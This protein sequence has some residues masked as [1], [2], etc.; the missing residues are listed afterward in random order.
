MQALSSVMPL[1]IGRHEGMKTAQVPTI[2][3]LGQL[4]PGP[5]CDVVE[6]GHW[7]IQLIESRESNVEVCLVE[8]FATADQIA[9][10]RQDL[11]GPPLRFKTFWCGP[12]RRM[13]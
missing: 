4:I 5:K 7:P 1:A 10:D 12:L 2:E 3:R 9:V 8:D 11:E 6:L 13:G